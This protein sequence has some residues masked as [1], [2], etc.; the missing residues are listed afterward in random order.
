MSVPVTE[1]ERFE[2]KV[3]KTPNGEMVIDYGQNLAGYVEFTIDAHAGELL[4]LT[5]GESLDDQLL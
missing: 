5:H 1:M 2:G 4:I 3:I